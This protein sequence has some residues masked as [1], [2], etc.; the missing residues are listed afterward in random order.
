MNR[1]RIETVL[2]AV[3]FAAICLI[4]FVWI[5]GQYDDPSTAIYRPLIYILF[6]VVLPIMLFGA[7]SYASQYGY[8]QAGLAKSIVV[9]LALAVP[10]F[11]LGYKFAAGPVPPLIVWYAMNI[12]EETY[13][14]GLLQR[15]G[16]HMAG[17]WGALFI[18]AVLFGVYHLT[19]GF[20][21]AQALGP[22]LLG[23]L[24]G[25]LRKDTD[26]IAG[27]ILMHMA[28]VTGMWFSPR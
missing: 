2:A 20:T 5:P 16:E 3:S 15:A 17:A 19:V 6:G 28:L 11:V 10:L 8:Q 9:S 12:L 24:F 13:F 23:V 26:N 14:R 18:P 4:Y 7:R 27:P 21:F 1:T 25:W 22:V